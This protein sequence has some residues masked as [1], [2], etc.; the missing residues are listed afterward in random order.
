MDPAT[1]IEWG[2]PY[3]GLPP[4]LRMRQL[5]HIKLDE[6]SALGRYP[7]I[8]VS[9]HII[10][11]RKPLPSSTSHTFDI[12]GRPRYFAQRNPGKGTGTHA[13][14]GEDR[15]RVGREIKKALK[16]L[17]LSPKEKLGSDLL[18]HTLVYSTIGDEGLDF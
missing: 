5:I 13:G 7:A 2:L 8:V 15:A 11:S 6:Q 14:K 4:S 10:Q 17:P 1:R 16:G 12:Q 3:L 18:F 9:T